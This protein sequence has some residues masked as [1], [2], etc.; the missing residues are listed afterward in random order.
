ML[1]EFVFELAHISGFACLGLQCMVVVADHGVV[2]LY[3][4]GYGRVVGY[5]GQHLKVVLAF[6]AVFHV[7]EH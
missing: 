7:V 4:G 1:V 6:Y 3:C 5:C 2:A